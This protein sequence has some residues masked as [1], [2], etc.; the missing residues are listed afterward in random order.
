MILIPSDGGSPSA[1]GMLAKTDGT[2][3]GN[4]ISSIVRSGLAALPRAR[5]ISASSMRSMHR[6]MGSKWRAV[7][8]SM[9]SMLRGWDMRA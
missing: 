5:T 3:V 7:V 4:G 1:A 8:P 9:T 2:G 6:S